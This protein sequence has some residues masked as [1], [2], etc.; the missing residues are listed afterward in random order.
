MAS[1]ILSAKE[2]IEYSDAELNV[3]S[4]AVEAV[5][6]AEMALRREFRAK[7]AAEAEAARQAAKTRDILAEAEAILTG[8]APV[9][10]ADEAMT[11]EDTAAE[12][13][14]ATAVKE[15]VAEV[16]EVAE[17]EVQPEAAVTQET[18]EAVAEAES[19]L[20]EPESESLA[21]EPL[22]TAED[23]SEDEDDADAEKERGKKKA[24]DKKR[25]LVFDEKLGE[26]VAERRRKPSRRGG[27]LD[28]EEDE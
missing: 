24:R 6:L 21:F 12:V 26:V 14:L 25:R 27:W 2:P 7:Q 18:E 8:Q 17:G 16:V 11:L 20:A 19:I 13:E 5:N 4:Q 15:E 9:A 23:W 28:Y 10:E 22:A 1:A 3:L